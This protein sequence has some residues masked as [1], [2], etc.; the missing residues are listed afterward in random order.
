MNQIR[1]FAQTIPEHMRPFG[2]VRVLPAECGMMESYGGFFEVV[3]RTHRA[4]ALFYITDFSREKKRYSITLCS[5]SNEK[6][7]PLLEVCV[8]YENSDVYSINI[9]I[10]SSASNLDMRG[11]VQILHAL[12]WDVIISRSRALNVSRWS[13]HI[14]KTK[15]YFLERTLQCDMETIVSSLQMITMVHAQK[16][17]P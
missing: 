14:E 10:V 15:R 3:Y 4:Q 16:S 12:F 5:A 7:S 11:V 2:F 13:S 8:H 9:D 17:N 1:E 6:T